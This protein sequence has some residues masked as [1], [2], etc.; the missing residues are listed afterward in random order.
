M[1][2]IPKP[3]DTLCR[4]IKLAF[5]S[6]Q[7]GDGAWEGSGVSKPA[8]QQNPLVFS[9]PGDPGLISP[10][11][12]SHVILP[13]ILF[14]ISQIKSSG[15]LLVKREEFGVSWFRPAPSL[16]F[17]TDLPLKCSRLFV[18]LSTECSRSLGGVHV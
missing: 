10:D 2:D 7:T 12:D 14:L 13:H 17:G 16:S 18:S 4:G 3:A 5:M 9:T 15:E 6:D 11:F 8:S 1:Q